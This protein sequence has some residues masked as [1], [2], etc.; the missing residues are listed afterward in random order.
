MAKLPYMQFFP[1]DYIK[2]TRLLSLQARGAWMDLLCLM[3]DSNPRGV[4]S[5]NY[6]AYSRLFGCDEP[7]AKASIE[8][9]VMAKIC[10]CQ[11]INNTTVTL[12]CRRMV[13]DEKLRNDGAERQRRLREKGG[14]DPE[15]W[16]SIRIKILERDEYSCAYC[17]RRA[18]TVDH[19]I[20]K[21]RGGDEHDFN[22]VACCKRCNME[23]TNKTPEEAGLQFW[24]SFQYIK[25]VSH[26]CN[27]K[28]TPYI[29]ESIIQKPKKRKESIAR[30][31]YETKAW[32]GITEEI[33]SLWS[34]R[35]PALNIKAEL[36]KM[37]TWLD[38]HK[39]NRKNDFDKFISNWLIRNQ[40]S[41]MPVSDQKQ[42]FSGGWKK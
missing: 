42:G 22:L 10:D 27:I 5:H 9:L 21:S 6:Q 19:V 34:E 29:P 28:V 30:Y 20:P 2:D 41:A 7:T 4:V 18:N 14:G 39:K 1:G 17:G 36:N 35:F 26:H 13:K 15:K 16:A 38:G 8:E 37:A 33:I 32:E 12:S 3:W 11:D 40:D 23:K 31:D 24:K 25:E